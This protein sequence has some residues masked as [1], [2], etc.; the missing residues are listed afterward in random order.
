MSWIASEPEFITNQPGPLVFLAAHFSTRQILLRTQT[1]HQ[2]GGRG[3]LHKKDPPALLGAKRAAWEAVSCP[4]R[5]QR[6]RLVLRGRLR[7]DE[8]KHPASLQSNWAVRMKPESFASRWP[9]RTWC[10]MRE[11]VL[12]LCECIQPESCCASVHNTT[13]HIT[14]WAER[15]CRW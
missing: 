8:T 4:C 11:A 12:N 1:T 9:A 7:R 10:S 15:R 2:A 6:R 3:T 13:Q 5:W 14:S